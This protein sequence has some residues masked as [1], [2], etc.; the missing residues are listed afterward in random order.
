M[1]TQL[2]AGRFKNSCLHVMDEVFETGQEVVVTKRGRPVVRILPARRTELDEEDLQGMIAHQDED[3]SST[4]ER[5][6][7][8]E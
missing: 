2:S 1:K 4:G 5:W 8:E 3:I 7:A 6:D